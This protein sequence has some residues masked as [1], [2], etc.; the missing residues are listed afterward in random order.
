MILKEVRTIDLWRSIREHIGSGVG[1]LEA[2][3]VFTAVRDA[4]KI[5]VDI[6]EV[7][8][9]KGASAK[10]I[11]EAKGEKRL[12][13]FDSFQGIPEV[14]EI[15]KPEFFKGQYAAS[16]DDVKERLKGYKN[17]YFYV[18]VFPGSSDPVK[19]LSF[20]FVH[21]DVDTYEST[22]NCLRFFYPRMSPGGIIISHDYPTVLGVRKA[23]E[24]FFRDKVEPAVRLAGSQCM[25][26]KL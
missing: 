15:D 4:A 8:V 22:L 6:A 5:Q 9:Y 3:Q 1:D 17:V 11:C 25:V 23:F 21:L 20:S 13:L 12:H 18:G 10:L 16:L 7:G 14:S 24:E 26:V 2:C 19:D